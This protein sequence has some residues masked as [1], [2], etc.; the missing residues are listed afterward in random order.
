MS[1]R[2]T[3]FGTSWP[4]SWP[5]PRICIALRFEQYLNCS[6]MQEMSPGFTVTGV[7]TETLVPVVDVEVTVLVA[8]AEVVEMLVACVRVTVRLCVLVRVNVEEVLLVVLVFV[9]V[10]VDEVEVV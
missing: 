9:V 8:V 5:F 3:Q 10:T 4:N 7:G 1:Y 2:G 6:G